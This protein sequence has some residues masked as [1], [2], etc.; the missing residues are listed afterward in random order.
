M[1]GLRIAASFGITPNRLG[2]C[3]P[4][5]LEEQKILRNYLYL[6]KNPAKA[7]KIMSRF[8]GAYS[9]YLLIARKNKIKDP[10]DERVVSA[11]WIGNE[12][13]EKVDASDLKKM[14]LSRFTKSGLLKKDEAM[15][16]I[17]LIPKNAKPHHSFHVF[18]LGTVTGKIDLN[19]IKLKDICRP[20]WGRI[21]KVDYKKSEVSVEYQPVTNLYKLGGIRIKKVDWDKKV[22]PELKVGE[23]VAFHWNTIAKRL[24]KEE[25]RNIK[26]YTQITLISL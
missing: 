14:V 24:T 16:R 25:V 7:R 9:Y 2:F 20:G 4:Q 23:W 3:G 12:L 10:F 15:R 13:L 6:G 5:E 17:D 11:Y 8:E 22:I 19:T 26:K 18:I 21:K 1:G